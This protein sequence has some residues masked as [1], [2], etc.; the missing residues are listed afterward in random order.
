MRNRRA[1]S[2]VVIAVFG[3]LLG[4]MTLAFASQPTQAQEPV[5]QTYTSDDAAYSFEYPAESTIETSE[6]ASLRYKLAYVQFPVTTTGAYQGVSVMVIENPSNQPLRDLVAGKYAEAKQAPPQVARAA[7]FAVNGRAAIKLERDPVAGDLDKYTVLVQGDG[8]TY[9]INLFGGGVGGQVEPTPETEAIFIR[10]V[11][12]FKVSERLPKPRE[13]PNSQS[14]IPNL[15]PAI[16]TVF[17]YPLRSGV[18]QGYGV[19]IGIVISGTRMEWLDYGIRNL[20]QWRTKCYGVDW[21]RAIHTGEDWY[22][23]DYLTANTAG[24]PVYAV[25]DGVVA[26]HNPGISYPGNVVLIRHRLANGRTIYSMYGHVANVRVVVGQQ[27]TRGQQIATVLN[28]GYV[29]RTPAKHPTWDSHLHF[30]MRYIEHA[31]NIYVPGRNAYG[32]NYPGCTYAYPGRGYTY[33][34]HPNDYPYPNAG[35]TDPSDFIAANLEGPSGVCVPQELLRNGNFEL[36]RTVWG[37]TNS[38]GANDPLIYTTRPRTGRWSGWLGNRANYTDTLSQGVQVPANSNVLRLSFWRYVQSKEAAG[39]ADDKMT[40]R[41]SNP[42]GQPIATQEVATSAA[43]RN[44]W[45]PFTTEFNLAGYAF[46][47]VLLSLTGANDADLVSSFFV[48]DASLQTVCEGSDAV[49][50]RLGD[51]AAGDV[52]TERLYEVRATSAQTPTV[53][54]PLVI[55]DVDRGPDQPEKDMAAPACTNLLVNG[56]F[57][58]GL[59]LPWSGIANTPSAIYNVIPGGANTSLKDT[60]TDA[61]RAYS[62]LKSGR[63]GSPS[64][65]GY[66][67]ELVQTVTLPANVTSVALSY[68][69]YLDTRETNTTTSLDRFEVGLES[70]EGIQLVAPQKIDNRDAKRG[71]W[72]QHALNLPNPSTYSGQ[73]IWVTVKGSVDNANPSSFLVDDVELN[74]CAQP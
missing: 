4:G 67:N 55:T 21:S 13:I 41:L 73:S 53:F 65:N 46:S 44:V 58:S 24:S 32:Y 47:T 38:A 2:I 71:Q 26:Q 31:G 68:W 12:S 30:E 43:A 72:V 59:A 61:S 51:V 3:F 8:V 52:P 25:A 57:E 15:E 45:Q 6:D 17:T 36:G 56:G 33:I 18:S 37:A 42:D 9:R 35:Y 11:N 7:G 39:N 22:R 62:G 60:L 63:V 74:V 27:V 14:L 66:W 5:W 28:Q 20:D 16:A 34:V 19:P 40:L 64:V 49:V 50:Q 54:L 23:D 48:D 69:R 10:L 1:F 70:D 29:G